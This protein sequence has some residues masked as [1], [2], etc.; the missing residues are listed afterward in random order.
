MLHTDR[1][2][3]RFLLGATEE[4]E[5]RVRQVREPAA[6]L[7]DAREASLCLYRDVCGFG[8]RLLEDLRDAAIAIQSAREQMDGLH[9][10][11]LALVRERLRAGHEGLGVGCVLLEVDGLLHWL[12][13]R[14]W[15]IEGIMGSLRDRLPIGATGPTIAASCLPMSS[16]TR[17]ITAPIATARKRS[18]RSGIS[19][20]TRSMWAMTTRSEPGS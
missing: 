12:R 19:R 9:L 20:S 15:E 10:R 18:S 17:P 5:H 11:V 14:H 7:A 16:S 13:V 8:T 4:I 1:A 6:R 2:S 3:A